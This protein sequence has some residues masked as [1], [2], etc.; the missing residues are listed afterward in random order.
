MDSRAVLAS[1]QRQRGRKEQSQD[2]GR[3]FDDGGRGDEREEQRDQQYGKYQS[4]GL[5]IL[6]MVPIAVANPSADDSQ[7]CTL[8]RGS[9]ARSEHLGKAKE[10][11]AVEVFV[12]RK[13]RRRACDRVDVA[14]AILRVGAR[15]ECFD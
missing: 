4:H 12:L 1:P 13:E 2:E 8:I 9:L 7:K 10:D 6:E 14:I 15:L 3:D 5:V 11:S